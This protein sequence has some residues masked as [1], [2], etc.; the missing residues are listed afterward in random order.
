MSNGFYFID[1]LSVAA[2][3]FDLFSSYSN[4]LS[5]SSLG[6]IKFKVTSIVTR[7]QG[8]DIGAGSVEQYE[9]LNI[10][11]HK[12]TYDVP[13]LEKFKEAFRNVGDVTITLEP[14]DDVTIQLSMLKEEVEKA[15]DGFKVVIES[16]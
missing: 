14:I 13:E 12:E 9:Q 2:N 4:G 15:F 3:G 16:I 8:S 10:W 1:P 11:K 7:K 6:F 5:V